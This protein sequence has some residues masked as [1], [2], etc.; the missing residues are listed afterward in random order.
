MP[1]GYNSTAFWRAGMTKKVDAQTTHVSRYFE[2]R[3]TLFRISPMAT[4]LL[5]ILQFY[6]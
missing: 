4:S 6:F 1:A 3:I 5:Q 2:Y